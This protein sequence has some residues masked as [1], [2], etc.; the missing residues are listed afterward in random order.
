VSSTPDRRAPIPA[1]AA[2]AVWCV[3]WPLG[4]I[5]AAQLVLTSMGADLDD[6]TTGESCAAAAA[7]WLMLVAGMA[8][9]SRSFGSGDLLADLGVRFRPVDL[10]GIP[11]GF[12]LQLAVVPALYWPLE[13]LWPGTF[14]PDEVEERAREL[15]D[16]AGDGWI[17]LLA[18]VVVVGAPVVEEL[19]YRGLL[20]RALGGSLGRWLAWLVV[21]AW[22]ALIH[23][24]PVEYPGL[25]LAGLTFGLGVLLTDRIGFGLTTHIAF[26]AAGLAVVLW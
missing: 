18:A 11:A 1:G 19:T 10:L 25:F 16:K 6:L 20:Q 21:S 14:G 13:Q 8:Y 4:V 17:W 2:V 22:F 23:F 12:A 5:V 26:N 3:A 24:S 7:G 15:V 9:A